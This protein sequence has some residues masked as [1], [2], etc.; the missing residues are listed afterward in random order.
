MCTNAVARERRGAFTMPPFLLVVAKFEREI[1]RSKWQTRAMRP[2]LFLA[3]VT[4]GCTSFGGASNE[5]TDAS[6]PIP[7][8]TTA[9]TTSPDGGT[10][11]PSP[12]PPPPAPAK[13]IFV[14]AGNYLGAPFES[15]TGDAGK[16]NGAIRLCFATGEPGAEQ[17][18]PMAPFPSDA[19]PPASVAG[20]VPGSGGA[21][22]LRTELSKTPLTLIAINSQALAE[23]ITKA[24][25]AERTMLQNAKCPE[26]LAPT[27]NGGALVEQTD[28]LNLGRVPAGVLAPEKTYLISL[29]GCGP[30]Y[31]EVGG[32]T[33]NAVIAKCGATYRN[34]GDQSLK[35]REVARPQV[36]ANGLGAQ[37]VHV[38][39]GAH[40]TGTSGGATALP[41]QVS[42]ETSANGSMPLTTTL[43]PYDSAMSPPTTLM[44][45]SLASDRLTVSKVHAANHDFAF[46]TS[47]TLGRTPV[48]LGKP[49]VFVLVGE[50]LPD[51]SFSNRALHVLAVPSNP[52]VPSP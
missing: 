38:A 48:T 10:I 32:V 51:T 49:F 1:R 34:T 20:F 18:A 50:G 4:F 42:V 47:W 5:G 24:S 37:F 28:Y 16:N 43:I 35:V 23:R 25:G 29:Q 19:I 6:S 22:P 12:P 21:L 52:E 45:V 36:A 17:V 41:V 15:S 8:G 33:A 27:L 31:F 30:K 3:F 11:L 46:A 14:H 7:T 44:N 13:L 9:A 40:Y 26:L 2:T 39:V